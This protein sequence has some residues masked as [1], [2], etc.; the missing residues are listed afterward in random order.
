M[1]TER[2]VRWVRRWVALYTRGLPADVRRDRADELESD[3]WSQMADAAETGEGDGATG[4]AIVARLVLGILAD[5][6]W[7]FDQRSA[8][9]APA[10]TVENPTMFARNM[11]I[12]AAIG[13]FA[14]AIWIVPAVLLGDAGWSGAVGLVTV[15][16]L[17]VGSICVSL[18]LL[19]FVFGNIDRLHGIASLLG[20]IGSGLGLL[21]IGG[22]FWGLV[23]LPVGSAAVMLNLVRLGVVGSRLGRIHAAS[24]ITSAIAVLP[25]LTN[26]VPPAS[27]SWIHYVILAI[28]LELYA[29]SWVA[30]GWTQR[31]G[32]WMPADDPA[33]GA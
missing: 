13:G 21:L 31:A 28:A 18:A 26:L 5:I 22:V 1:N 15:I 23:L 25:L 32:T 20:A 29:L 8:T 16:C 14:W 12:I 24:A 4:N 10:I 3:L 11:A 9:T 2:S 30:I 17:L 19:A 7:R 27:A 6:R 33:P